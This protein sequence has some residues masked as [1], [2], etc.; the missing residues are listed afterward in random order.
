MSPYLGSGHQLP[1]KLTLASD[2][3]SPV[4]QRIGAKVLGLARYADAI[5]S[6]DSASWSLRGRHVPGCTSTHR[7]ES[8]CTR[9]AMAWYAHVTKHLSAP[10]PEAWSRPSETVGGAA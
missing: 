7:S 5:A 6:S 10:E 8:N 1:A 9:F 2:S 3:D 4:G